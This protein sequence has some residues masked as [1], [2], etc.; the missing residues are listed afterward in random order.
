MGIDNRQYAP[1]PW[2]SRRR[3]LTLRQIKTSL[4][5]KGVLSP[6]QKELVVRCGFTSK[7]LKNIL[8]VLL[9]NSDKM[10]SL[11]EIGKAVC[12]RIRD[13]KLKVNE[14]H[15]MGLRQRVIQVT[16]SGDLLIETD[17]GFRI[18]DVRLQVALDSPRGSSS[19][20]EE[21]GAAESALHALEIIEKRVEE[22]RGNPKF[23]FQQV[24]AE[25]TSVETRYADAFKKNATL[26]GKI[27]RLRAI[28]TQYKEEVWASL[29]DG[30]SRE[31]AGMRKV[32]TKKRYNSDLRVTEM[33]H[34]TRKINEKIRAALSNGD[35][36]AKKALAAQLLP[37]EAIMKGDRTK[38]EE[39][40]F[41]SEQILAAGMR[42]MS[43][44]Y[45]QLLEKIE[46]EKTL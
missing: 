4:K 15:M 30:P 17:Q 20:M 1:P 9:L 31:E 3:G 12:L 36:A 29:R 8:D 37:F 45:D 25:I 11:D 33:L 5:T 40:N 6:L 22:G 10:C 23:D 46:Q 7:V 21:Q 2:P 16:G 44:L 19:S 42:T 18:S 38:L 39:S 34:Q 32:P 28:T 26:Q 41:K 24:L 14:V 13:S 27:R 43:E 35:L